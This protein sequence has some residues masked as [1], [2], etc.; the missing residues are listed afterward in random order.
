M[1]SFNHDLYR[2]LKGQRAFW[3]M[4]QG[5]GQVNWAK[6]NALPAE[7]AVALWTAQAYAHGASCVSYFR[8]R[9]A[10]IAQEL[11]HSGLLRHDETLDRG[12]LEVS[13]IDLPGAPNGDTPARVALLHD[14]ESLW[15]NDEQPHSE[16]ATYWQSVDAL[17]TGAPL[18]RG[19]C[20]YSSSGP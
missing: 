16:R 14:Y 13:D 5:N 1:I 9:A 4:E 15:I 10:T 7:G 20:R 17:S 11:M 8:W 18:T 19:R 12:G 6:S 3:V 2:G